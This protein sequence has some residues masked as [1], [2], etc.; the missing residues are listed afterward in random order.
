[1]VRID[2]LSGSL[3]ENHVACN[4]FIY[5]GTRREDRFGVIHALRALDAHR[6]G[7]AALA[8]RTLP[9]R[10]SRVA[11]LDE[12]PPLRYSAIH[13]RDIIAASSLP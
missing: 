8:P 5:S 2:S 7:G 13:D 6:A 10:V 11:P 3:Q 9:A 1:M 12:P 4:A